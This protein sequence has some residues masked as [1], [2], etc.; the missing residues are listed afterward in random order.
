MNQEAGVGPLDRSVGYVMKQTAMALRTGMEAVLRPLGLSVAQ[1]ACLELLG[2]HPRLSNAELARGAFV[3]RQSMNLVL[4][5]LAKRDLLVRPATAPHGRVRPA[6]LTDAGRRLLEVASHA[7]AD[8]EQQMLSPLSD[9]Q[10]RRLLND[11]A[12]CCAALSGAAPSTPAP[13]G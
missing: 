7:V 8:V 10:Q 12:A 5:G 9:T 11:L 4:R 3:S 13:H 6:A 2:Q 1:Y